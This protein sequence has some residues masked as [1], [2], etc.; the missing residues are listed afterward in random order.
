MRRLAIA[1]T[2]A[3][4][5]SIMPAGIAESQSIRNC[6]TP[7]TSKV[8]GLAAGGGATCRSAKKTARL[9]GNRNP[10]RAITVNGY[11]CRVANRSSAGRGWA[12]N[13]SDGKFVS[14][15]YVT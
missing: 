1:A 2:A 7:S 3:T 11:R 5:L 12:C 13:K 10:R 8:Q 6:S 14:W 15:V 4:S 9:V